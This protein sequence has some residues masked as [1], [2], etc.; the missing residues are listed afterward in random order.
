MN[1]KPS[2]SFAE[3][4]EEIPLESYEDTTDG[5]RNGALRRSSTDAHTSNY[6][7]PL[8]VR[9][10]S[11]STGRARQFSEDGVELLTAKAHEIGHANWQ[12]GWQNTVLKKRCKGWSPRS[13]EEEVKEIAQAMEEDSRLMTDDVD[14][15]VQR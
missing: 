14:G 5:P 10:N 15:A 4:V 13:E 9:F 11:L 3:I 12:G 8:R 7:P 2:T 1:S 6:H